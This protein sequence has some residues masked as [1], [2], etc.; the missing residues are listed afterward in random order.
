VASTVLCAVALLAACAHLLFAW[1]EMLAWTPEFV[2]RAAPGWVG[3]D[4]AAAEAHVRWA[5]RL[6]FNVGAYNLLLSVGLLWNAAVAFTD[7]LLARK[8]GLF[9]SVWLLAAA[10]AAAH[11]GIRA[12]FI[13]QGT[14]GLALLAAA[15]ATRG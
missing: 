6:A 12:A 8:L 13:A 1:R 11:T 4:L 5:A 15:L 7:P 14:L 9:F 3:P 2:R 10:A